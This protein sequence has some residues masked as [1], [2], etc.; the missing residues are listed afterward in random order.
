MC[1]GL[2]TSNQKLLNDEWL[3]QKLKLYIFLELNEN[4]NTAHSNLRIKIIIITLQS[5]KE[6]HTYKSLYFKNSERAKRNN[7]MCI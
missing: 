7:V 6:V 3:I 5:Y 1:T 4:K 2:W